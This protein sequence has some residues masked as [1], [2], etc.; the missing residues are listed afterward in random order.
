MEFMGVLW[1][2]GPGLATKTICFVA[3]VKQTEPKRTM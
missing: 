3:Q 2:F 1:G